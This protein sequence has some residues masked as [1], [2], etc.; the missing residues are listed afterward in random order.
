M[1]VNQLLKKSAKHF[2]LDGLKKEDLLPVFNRLKE[3]RYTEENV[4]NRLGVKDIEFI[5]FKYLPIYLRKQL[6]EDTRL[7]KAIRLFLLNQF[8][9]KH[10]AVQVFSPDLLRL[11][12]EV[13]L[14]GVETEGF[15]AK[16]DLF[17]CMDGYFAS[18]HR[19]SSVYSCR[20]VYPPGLDSYGLARGM[21]QDK[22]RFTLDLCT[23][24]GIQA[25]LAARF[26]DMVT[27]IDI[28][29]RAINFANFNALLNQVDNVT[30]IEGDLYEPVGDDKFTRI[31]A[32]PQLIPTPKEEEELS[33]NGKSGENI[34]KRIIE[35][36]PKHL[37]DEGYAQVFS[38]LIFNRNRTY[39]D[40][41]NKWLK[42]VPFQ[43]LVAANRYKE[44]E[45][46]I[47][48]Q[49]HQEKDFEEYSR[50]LIEWFEAYQKEEI[51]KL[52]D[53]LITMKKTPSGKSRSYLRDT[54]IIRKPYHNKIKHFVDMISHLD[55]E[56][57][58][59]DLINKEFSISDETDFWWDGLNKK[60]EKN[61]GVLF[62]DNALFIDEKLERCNKIILDIMESGFT[63]GTEIL[64]E[65]KNK[66]GKLAE[67]D[68]LKFG[69]CMVNLMKNGIIVCN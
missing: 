28:N 4:Y 7:D 18:D 68:R 65:L 66:G 41:L 25:I 10:E 29:P 21:I 39:T 60:S 19:F 59:N 63:K 40:K 34:L 62:K 52:A 30:F 42:N 1:R 44:I 64:K 37:E 33:C 5:M 24:T 14:L 23:G 50:M 69:E 58:L 32:N 51:V 17:P 22:S 3:L 43:V 48:H 11:C 54:H 13:G 47:S 46:Y 57:Y 9:N 38:L 67:F 56:E 26:S 36:I 12:T 45:T 8:L 53:G 15:Y 31:L 27:G 2:K 55:N 6:T 61:Y 20:H 35:G 16:V 49:I